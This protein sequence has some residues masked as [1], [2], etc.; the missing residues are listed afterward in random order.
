MG[1]Y[2]A[3]PVAL[4]RAKS[5]SGIPRQFK[6][7][8][9]KFVSCQHSRNPLGDRLLMTEWYYARGGQQNG[10]VTFEQLLELAGNGGLDPVKDQVWTAAMKDW[11]PAGQVPGLF[12][13]A[14]GTQNG[15]QEHWGIVVNVDEADGHAFSMRLRC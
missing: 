10:P 6:D 11:T 4:K 12:T 3:G 7:W 14:P 15:R 13:A 2:V 1:W 5:F 9:R 8:L